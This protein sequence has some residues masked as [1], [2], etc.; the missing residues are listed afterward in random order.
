VHKTFHSATFYLMIIGKFNN[1]KTPSHGRSRG[2]LIKLV[3][4]HGLAAGSQNLD[5]N[6]VSHSSTQIMIVIVIIQFKCWLK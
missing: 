2:V 6:T 5:F 3:M 4:R 1:Q